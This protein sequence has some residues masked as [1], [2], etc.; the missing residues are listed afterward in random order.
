MMSTSSSVYSISIS[1][2]ESNKNQYDYSDPEWELAKKKPFP[3]YK[4]F[5]TS[6]IFLDLLPE[7]ISMSN[8]S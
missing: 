1:M 3:C 2:G 5:T 6:F 4:I 7:L 8:V